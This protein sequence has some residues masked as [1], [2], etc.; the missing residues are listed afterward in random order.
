MQN[1]QFDSG[2]A[3]FTVNGGGVL[4]FNP[5]DPNVYARFYDATEKIQAVEQAL[6]E[7]TKAEDPESA[8][9]E[10]IRIMEE[11]DRQMKDILGWVF[12]PGND[13]D[14]LLEGINLLAVAANGERVITNLFAALEPVLI[15][16]AER[17][18]RDKTQ[19]AVAKAKARRGGK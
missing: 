15:E 2:I 8:A 19:V 13:F 18:A 3:E 4:R 14:K 7:K 6:V 5:G 11:A 1:I 12:G 17:C 10:L 9:L 16:G